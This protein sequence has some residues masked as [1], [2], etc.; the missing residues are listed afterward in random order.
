MAGLLGRIAVGLGQGMQVYGKAKLDEQ[1]QERLSSVAKEM[2]LMRQNFQSSENQTN[3]DLTQAE[4]DKAIEA[5][6]TEGGLDREQSQDQFNRSVTNTKATTVKDVRFDDNTG[7]DIVTMNDGTQRE[8]DPVTDTFSKRG[9]G[10]PAVSAATLDTDQTWGKT[11]ANKNARLFGGDKK[12]FPF[13]G[14]EAKAAKA[15]G[16]F[17]NNARSK[18]ADALQE[19]NTKFAT[20]G[21]KYIGEL[22]RK[23]AEST[24][25]TSA[26][27]SPTALPTQAKDFAPLDAY[28]SNAGRGGVSERNALE[29]LLE[30]GKARQFEA[31]IKRRLAASQ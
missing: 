22:G 26:T 8:Y 19:F 23:E 21:F 20:Q 3:R 27:A 4:S 18:G 2:E 30:S 17:K 12:D 9:Q 6:A 1:R 5:R 24:S 29:R 11:E 13:F 15:A 10:K 25:S 16:Q 28:L 7:N 14:D 31:E